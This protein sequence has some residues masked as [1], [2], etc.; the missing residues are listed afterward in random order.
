[1]HGALYRQKQSM[2]SKALPVESSDI[3]SP[4]LLSSKAQLKCVCFKISLWDVK[5]NSVSI[6]C[7]ITK[8]RGKWYQ[9]LHWIPDNSSSHFTS[10]GLLT[11]LVLKQGRVRAVE[12]RG[13][14]GL[15]FMKNSSCVPGPA[16]EG[17]SNAGLIYQFITVWNCR[18]QNGLATNRSTG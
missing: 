12:S 15:K 7:L 14:D 11:P 18:G 8:A 17:Q 1:M 10:D 3:L 13:W 4:F 2:F 16:E 9:T 6:H 5:S